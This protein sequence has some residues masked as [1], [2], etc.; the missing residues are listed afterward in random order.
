MWGRSGLY[1]ITPALNSVRINPETGK[2]VP[3]F[4]LSLDCALHFVVVSSRDAKAVYPNCFTE[5][6]SLRDV[7]HPLNHWFGRIGEGCSKTVDWYIVFGI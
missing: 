1:L 6:L 7:K 4:K 5:R 3:D 2:W